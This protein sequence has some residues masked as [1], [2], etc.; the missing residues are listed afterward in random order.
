MQMAVESPLIDLIELGFEFCGS[1]SMPVIS[2]TDADQGV[3]NKRVEN[4]TFTKRPK[5]T[6]VMK[7]NAFVSRMKGKKGSKKA[8]RALR[9]IKDDSA[10][11]ME[12][13]LAMLLTL[14]YMLG[15]YGI[16]IAKLNQRITPS[17]SAQQI[18]NKAYYSCD[19]YWPEA[20]LAVEYDSDAFHALS[21]RIAADSIRRNA[22]LSMGIT[23]ITVTNQQIQ[24]FIEFDRFAVQLAACL[25]K[26]LRYQDPVF[27][28]KQNLLRSKLLKKVRFIDA[29]HNL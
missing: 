10:S 6:N 21:E 14:P 5:L 17:K 1:Y 22:L 2:R 8:Q 24:S 26:R 16:P 28:R 20:K 19:I 12:T 4:N 9:Y 13:K 3:E 23:V 15:G 11:P 27:T 7:L 18:M 29:L 25:G